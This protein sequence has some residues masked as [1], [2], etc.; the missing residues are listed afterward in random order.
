MLHTPEKANESS[1]LPFAEILFCIPDA[2][3]IAIDLNVF[4]SVGVK[5][6]CSY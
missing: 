1:E 6:K 4:I 5:S 3:G 2:K